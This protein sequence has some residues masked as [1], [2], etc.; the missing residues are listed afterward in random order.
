MIALTSIVMKCFEHVLKYILL[1][2]AEASQDKNQ[3]AYKK[4][5]STRDTCTV[6]DFL[7]RQHIETPNSYSR[8]LF[9][10]YSS[11]FNTVLPSI[12]HIR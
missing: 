10:D 12:N 9:I 3:Y 5:R 11:A 7:V 2:Y 4:Y 1:K 8:V 6:L